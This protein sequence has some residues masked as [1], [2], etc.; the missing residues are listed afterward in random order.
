MENLS[1]A[2][3]LELIT[4][5]CFFGSVD[6]QKAYYAVP[7]NTDFR[8]YLRFRWRD[9]LYE[10]CAMPNGLACAPKCFTKIIKV[11]FS[12]LRERGLESS[13][14]LD[15]SILFGRTAELCKSNIS[16]TV[17]VLT[18]VGFDIHPKKSVLEPTQVIT[19]LGFVIDSNNMKVFLPDKKVETIVKS[20]ND[21][22]IDKKSVTILKV[23]EFIGIVIAALPAFEFGRLYYRN[24]ERQKIQALRLSKGSYHGRLVLNEAATRDVYWWVTN[25]S[26]SGRDI[27]PHVPDIELCTDASMSGWGCVF[28][29]VKIGGRWSA[30]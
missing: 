7:V 13:F 19:Y 9:T 6:L 2:C 15:D 17:D 20:G 12:K 30:E 3:A 16:N 24:L 23:A 29:D 4:P 10:Y 25:A 22:L 14:Y 1:C 21:L 5:G 26:N 8:R 28:S 27:L 11:L 18:S